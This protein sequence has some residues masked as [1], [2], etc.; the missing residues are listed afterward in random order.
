MKWRVCK[1]LKKEFTKITYKIDGKVFETKHKFKI[2]EIDRLKKLLKKIGYNSCEFYENYDI[3]K[4]A[5]P[6]SKNIQIV[7]SF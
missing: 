4:L 5:N 3:E 7:L 6:K 2:F 1:L